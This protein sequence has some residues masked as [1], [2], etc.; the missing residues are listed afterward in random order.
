MLKWIELDVELD[1][2]FVSLVLAVENIPPLGAV[3]VVD[4]VPNENPG[5]VE[6]CVLV[7]PAL[8]L[9]AVVV[10]FNAA[11]GREVVPKLNTGG[12]GVAPNIPEAEDV[13]L[14]VV[15]LAAG[16]EVN[17]NSDGVDD[18][19]VA[20]DVIFDGSEAEKMEVGVVLF[21]PEELGGLDPKG[22]LENPKL[23]VDVVLVELE[24]LVVAVDDKKLGNPVVVAETAV[25]DGVFVVEGT[26]IEPNVDAVV[27]DSVIL[28][29]AVGTADAVVVELVEVAV[30]G[31]PKDGL[32]VEPTGKTNEAIELVVGNALIE[33]TAVVFGA[34]VGLLVDNVLGI[35]LMVVLNTGLNPSVKGRETEG[36]D[37]V[38]SVFAELT[39][40]EVVLIV[41][42]VEENAVEVEP[43]SGMFVPRSTCA[44]NN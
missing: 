42:R 1:E 2:A 22:V 17:E 26:L 27:K 21:V 39:A 38:L 25:S 43:P 8:L 16:A 11:L 19:I 41:V 13:A 3:F 37:E 30:T 35:V 4:V 32:L 14:L 20:T 9:F 34:I 28:L 18:T 40:E 24:E 6:D 44:D 15:L 31:A 23:N 7:A 10:A 36:V 12:E 29:T 5:N 33:P